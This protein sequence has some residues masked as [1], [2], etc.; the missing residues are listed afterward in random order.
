MRRWLAKLLGCGLC[1]CMSVALRAGTVTL[2]SDISVN[3]TAEPTSELQPGQPVAF[4]ISVTNH[5]PEPVDRVILGSSAIRDEL[6]VYSTSSNCDNTLALSVVDLVDGYYFQ[7]DWLAASPTSPLAAG[8]T[9]SCSFSLEYLGAA[10]ELFPVAFGFP[11]WLFDLNN[12]NNS[13]V[14][15]LRRGTPGAEPIAL[16]LLPPSG[17]LLLAT[18]LVLLTWIQLRKGPVRAKRQA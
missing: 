12:D 7:Y 16:P 17:L 14:V 13:A 8:A 5:G 4:T 9:R 11:D 10:P 18:S 6:D 2:P 1:I 3:L 15:T